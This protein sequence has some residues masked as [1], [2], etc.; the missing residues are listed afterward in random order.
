M[1]EVNG[2]NIEASVSDIL[3]ALKH[4]CDLNGVS[5]FRSIK[6]G[7]DNIQFS[8]PFHAD[9]QEKH[10]SAGIST[11]KMMTRGKIVPAGT[12]HCFTCGYTAELTEFISNVFGRMDGGFFG[13]QWLK[14][15]FTT[16]TVVVRE[17]IRL[18]MER[19]RSEQPKPIHP[20]YVDEHTLDSYR[21]YHEYMWKRGLT[22]ELVEMFDI[23]YDKTKKVLTFPLHDADGKVPFI[24]TR[25]VGTKFH[26]YEKDVIKTN[27]LYGEYE[28]R[29]EYPDAKEWLVTESILNALTW[30]RYMTPKTG[31]PAVALMGVGG[32]EQFD[33]LAQLP[34]RSLILGLDPDK[35]GEVASEKIFRRLRRKKVIKKLE[36]PDWMYDEKKD[37]NDLGEGVVNLEIKMF[38]KSVKF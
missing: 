31:I 12:V 35:A 13:N 32:G 1:I 20:H 10:P 30:W 33:L 29:R 28:G 23:G 27:Y 3:T 38:E 16:A 4:Q 6:P 5:Y 14:K 7:N 22:E 2:L 25:S 34:G 19:G 18:N 17:P 37:I 21:Y 8:C 26:H 11:V 24:Q 15:N 9:G 36:Y